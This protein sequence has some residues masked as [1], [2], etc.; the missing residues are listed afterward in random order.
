[1]SDHGV[2]MPSIYFPYDFYRLEEQLPMLYAIINDR[3]NISYEE[4]YKYYNVENDIYI[5]INKHL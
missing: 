3:K 4:Q 2:G 1:M 5:K